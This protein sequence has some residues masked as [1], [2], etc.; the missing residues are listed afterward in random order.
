M[1]T[2][3]S[4][5]RSVEPR[6]WALQEGYRLLAWL[7]MGRAGATSGELR[8]GEETWPISSRSRRPHE[9]VAGDPADPIIAFDLDQATVRGVAE[10]IPWEF[11]GR[12]SR[13]RATLGAGDTAIVL[14]TFGWRPQGDAEITGDWEHRDA[15]VLACFFA[16]I[17]RRRRST[18]VGGSLPGV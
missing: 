8:A 3:L 17:A 2:K 12:M 11:G 13:S 9:V 4:I 10:P 7:Q 15:V 14:E 16:V 1:S 6:T 5:S 18:F